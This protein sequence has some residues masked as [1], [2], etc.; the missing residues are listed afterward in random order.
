MLDFNYLKK[1][2][3]KDISTFR[4]VKLAVLGDTATQFITQAIKGMGVEYAIN[5]DMYEADF[6]Q[7]SLQIFDP[8]SDLYRFNPEFTFI[9]ESSHKLL[10]KFSEMSPSDRINFA[11]KSI[12][13]IK[14]LLAAL[15][16]KIDSKIIFCN[17]TEEDDHVFGHFASKT[18]ESFP[19]QLRLLNVLL[20]ELAGQTANLFICDLSSIQNRIGHA[21]F[22]SPSIYI[23]TEM[24]VSIDALPYVAKAVVQIIMAVRGTFKKCIII[25]LDNTLWGGIIG[26]DGLENIQLGQLGIGKAFTEF[27][28]WLKKMQQRGIILAVCSKNTESVAKEPFEKHPDMILRLSDIAVFIANWNNKPD[29]IRRI[30]KILNI[31]FDSMVFLDDSAFER[32]MVRE[33]IP[34]ITIPELPED[35]ALYLDYLYSLNLFETASYSGE[36]A[37]RTVHYQ[38]EAER[39]AFQERFTNEDDFLRS[40][41]MQSEIKSFDAFTFPRIAQLSQRSNQFNLRT[42]RY[43]E[44]KLKNI[45]QSSNYFTL[46]F[47]LEDKFGDNGLIC[48]VILEK[49]DNR[50]LFIDTWFM[51][52]RVLKRGVE[53]YVLN[54]IVELARANDYISIEGEYIP[55]PK[56]EM[57]REHYN[58]LGF[59]SFAEN[60]WRL[61]VEGYEMKNN[62]IKRK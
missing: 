21:R 56:N 31:G 52:C 27:Q 48:A 23:N 14:E 13:H 62:F 45:A 57:V 29:N 11:E 53:N 16:N 47:T 38:R 15:R 28:R 35:P 34:Q 59:T 49:C 33:N 20:Q 42:V 1:N 50:T 30:Q 36:D 46:S 37:Q 26:D 54:A 22:C 19:Y 6:N 60:R 32:N 3:K 55:T 10:Q 2:L 51:S 61:D 9:F 43:T 5:I 12:A 4:Q 8:A 44:D 18:A 24:L 58:N 25:D 39:N 40:L 41:N 7:I 17:Y